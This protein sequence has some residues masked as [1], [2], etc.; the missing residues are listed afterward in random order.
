MLAGA[1]NASAQGPRLQLDHLDTLADRS[2]ETVD[3]TVDA[4]MLKATAGFLVGKGGDTEQ[5]QH[6]LNGI[7]FDSQ[8]N[9]IFVTGKL[10]PRVFEIV[11]K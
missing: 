6:L 10:W 7:A 2:K 5:L 9:R 3:V 11:V 1:R 4:A 8:K